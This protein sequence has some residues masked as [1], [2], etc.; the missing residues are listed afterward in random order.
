MFLALTRVCSRRRDAVFLTLAYAFATA[1]WSVAAQALWQHGPS[2]LLGQEKLMK[3][4]KLLRR[5]GT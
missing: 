3:L 5:L 2:L 1:T 4:K